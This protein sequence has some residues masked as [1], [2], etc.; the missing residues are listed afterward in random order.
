MFIICVDYM[1]RTSIDIMK[2]NVFKLAK[3]RSRKYSAQTITDADYADDIALLAN[4]PAQTKTLLHSLERAAGIG[5]HVNADKTEY[6]CFNESGDISVLKGASLKLVNKFTNLGSSVSSTKK[7]VNTWLAKPWNAIDRLLVIWKSD[8]SDKIERCF[9][10]A[11]VGLIL[12]YGCTIWTLTRRMEK[13]LNGNDTRMPRAILNESWRQHPSKQQ[14]YGHLPPITHTIKLRRIRHAVPCWRSK[15]E[16]ISDILLWTLSH[17][18]KKAWWPARTYIQQFCADT[19]YR[20]E[21][22][23]GAMD[24]RDGWRERATE[25][26]VGNVTRWW[27]WFINFTIIWNR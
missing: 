22:R 12:L 24:E 27:W 25:V 17:G 4:T 9:Y 21:D 13:K 20:L 11:A 14:L 26:R 8:L 23:L 1:L 3:E 15:D 16:L 6:I 19:G 10:Q 7:D 2:K 5:L 18:R